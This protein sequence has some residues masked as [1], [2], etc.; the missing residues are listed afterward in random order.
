[1]DEGLALIQKPYDL[2][3][4]LESLRQTLDGRVWTG[5]FKVR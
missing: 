1:M 2:D 4:L 5:S 3:H